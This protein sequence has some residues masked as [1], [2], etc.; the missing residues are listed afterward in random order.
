VYTLTLV[1]EEHQEFDAL[2][3]GAVEPGRDSFNELGRLAR[4]QHLVMLT[5]HELQLPAEDIQP[6]IALMHLRVRL[7]RDTI[8][9]DNDLVRVQPAISAGKWQ[10]HHPRRGNG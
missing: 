2:G 10:E 5:S 6:F 3:T 7:L 9:R 4:A 1:A 8:R